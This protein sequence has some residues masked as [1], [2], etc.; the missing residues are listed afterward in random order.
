MAR[1]GQGLAVAIT[2]L[3]VSTGCWND[4]YSRDWSFKPPSRPRGEAAPDDPAWIPRGIETTDGTTK[5]LE[6]TDYHMSIFGGPVA[7]SIRKEAPG[8]PLVTDRATVRVDLRVGFDHGLPGLAELAAMGVLET[9]DGAG[10]QPA[11][12][13]AVARLGGRVEAEVGAKWTRFTAT[14]PSVNWQSALRAITDSVRRDTLTQRQFAAIQDQLVQ[15]YLQEWRNNPLLSQVSQWLRHGERDRDAVLQAIEDRNLPEAALFR[16]RHFQPRGVA[17]GLWVPNSP[18]DPTF[19]L[20]QAL[21]AM[22]AWQAGPVPPDAAAERTT[23]APSGVRWIEG[24][25]TRSEVALIVPLSPATPEWLTLIESLSMG[26]IG[27]RLGEFLAQRLG[28][29]P[30]FQL[31]EMGNYNS[32][33]VALVGTVPTDKVTDVWRA[34]KAAWQSLAARPPT[35]D[36]LLAGVQ[37]ARLRLQR[38]QDHPDAWFEAVGLGL[39]Q[40]RT[41]GPIRD[42]LRVDKL[43]AQTIASAARKHGSRSIAMAVAGGTMPEQADPEFRKISGEIPE[44]TPSTDT[45]STAA[46]GKAEQFLRLAIQA[47]GDR[48]QFQVF[49]GY[50]SKET[51]RTDDGLIATVDNLYRNRGHLAR[52]LRVLSTSIYTTIQDVKGTETVTGKPPRKLS[53]GESANLLSE[54]ANHPIALLASYARGKTGFRYVG[55]RSLEGRRV[56]LLQRTDTSKPRLRITIDAHTG[57]LRTIETTL[58]R[59]GVGLVQVRESYDDYRRLRG[60]RVPMHQVSSVDGQRTRESV[61][62]SFEFLR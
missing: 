47:L 52:E 59:S 46:D 5:T 4:N 27:G 9:P 25:G 58:H 6:D 57:L 36:Q 13:T 53:A 34:A 14:V 24:P 44:H 16:R 18:K 50:R 1:T 12:R 33:Y 2:A 51:W 41:G 15:R 23:G 3:T 48:G 45:T 49:K 55:M 35:G 11:L 40:R 26:G 28:H 62:K 17:V 56:A 8:S 7:I 21:A 32:R 20:N 10:N 37:R 38:R 30:V 42:L 54:A 29:E 19:L 31:H 22:K 43:A 60:V 39:M 61:S